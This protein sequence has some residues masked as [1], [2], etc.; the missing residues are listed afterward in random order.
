MSL[1]SLGVLA[2]GPSFHPHGEGP[3]A[4]RGA[5]GGHLPLNQLLP[6]WPHSGEARRV[7]LGVEGR[8]GQRVAGAGR[9]PGPLLPPRP[10]S[11]VIQGLLIGRL[12]RHFSEEAL[13]WAS[14]LVFSLVGL[15]MVRALPPP[16]APREE[17]GPGPP[18]APAPFALEPLGPSHQGRLCGASATGPGLGPPVWGPRP[19]PLGDPR[20]H[21]P[22]L[23]GADV[24]RPPLLP[25]GAWPGLQPVCSQRGHRQHADQGRLGLRHG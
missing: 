13:L 21:G 17:Q 3:R 1:A 2:V 23:P 4:G 11:Q 22:V 15:A 12:S 20:H 16:D 9:S 6:G 25:P 18:P 8:G 14:V 19:W 5:R 7:Q 24:Q 10:L